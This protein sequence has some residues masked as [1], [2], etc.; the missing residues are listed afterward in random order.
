MTTPDAPGADALGILPAELS[1]E[2]LRRELKHV[3]AT[4]WDTL[5]DGSQAAF[6]THTR[7]MHQLEEEFLR[8]FPAGGD[9]HPMRTRAGARE[10]QRR[11]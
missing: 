8:R 1:D 7:R 10:E 9:P 2:D 4:R 5:N 6:D 11:E 3:Y